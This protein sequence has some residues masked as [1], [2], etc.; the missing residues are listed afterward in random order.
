MS[1]R[2]ITLP[3]GKQVSIGAYVRAWKVLKTMPFETLLPGWEWYEVEAGRIL[4][5]MRR[6]MHERI[7]AGRSYDQRGLS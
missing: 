4:A 7:N 2:A 3:S 1:I 5:D 6:G